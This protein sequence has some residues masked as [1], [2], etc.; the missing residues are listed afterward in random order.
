ME[1]SIVFTPALPALNNTD[2]VCSTPSPLSTTEREASVL[3]P[4]FKV[5]FTFEPA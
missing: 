5:T 2:S 1:V 3:V 4:S